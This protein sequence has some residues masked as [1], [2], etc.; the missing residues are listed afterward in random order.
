MADNDR[1]ELIYAEIPKYRHKV[2]GRVKFA[3]VDSAGIVHNV[4]YFYLLEWARTE[5]LQNLGINL[6]PNTFIREL[7]LMVVRNE[8]D[9]LGSLRFYDEYSI[10]TRVTE[11]KDSSFTF[12]QIVLS[13]NQKPVAGGSSVFVYVDFKEKVS[14]TVPDFLR[15]AIEKFENL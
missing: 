14:K 8:L 13:G 5:Y 11:V 15:N 12:R 7:P 1:I 10:L 6:E 9:Y 2:S 4:Q 3:E